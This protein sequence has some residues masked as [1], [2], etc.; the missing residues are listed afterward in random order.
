MQWLRYIKD[1]GKD[2]TQKDEQDKM[3]DEAMADAQKEM[4][5]QLEKISGE[6]TKSSEDLINHDSKKERSNIKLWW[7]SVNTFFVSKQE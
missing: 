7:R 5:G 2:T 3:M 1:I 6:V 4:E